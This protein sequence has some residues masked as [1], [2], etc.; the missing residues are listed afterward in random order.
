MAEFESKL[1]EIRASSGSAARVQGLPLLTASQFTMTF[2]T[3][4]PRTSALNINIARLMG[5][6]TTFAIQT[7]ARLVC[8]M[9]AVCNRCTLYR[10]TDSPTPVSYSTPYSGVNRLVFFLSPSCLN[11]YTSSSGNSSCLSLRGTRLDYPV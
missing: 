11:A 6:I 5:H 9:L 3:R 10:S 2:L 8:P 4:R 1:V 7:W